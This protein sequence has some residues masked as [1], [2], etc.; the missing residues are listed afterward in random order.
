[1]KYKLFWAIVLI[2]SVVGCRQTEKKT[3]H[4]HEAHK[5]QYTAYSSAHELFAEADP[6]IAGES[7]NVLSHF[8][9]LPD[10]KALEEGKITLTLTAG[11]STVQQTLGKPDRKGIYSFDLKPV[12]AGKGSLKYE[13]TNA[14]GEFTIEVPDVTV[15]ASDEEADAAAEANEQS[16]TNTTTFTKEQSWKID[17]NTGYPVMEPFGQVIKTT[18][19]VDAAIGSESVVVAKTA[20]VVIINEEL[21]AGKMVSKGEKLFTISGTGMAENNFSTKYSEAK[22]NFE[23]AKADLQRATELAKERIV[24]ER[25]LA[26]YKNIFDNA[27]TVFDNLNSNFSASGQTVTSPVSGYIR[28]LYVTNGSFVE[29][30]QRVLTVSQ[31]KSLTLHAEIP[32][33]YAPLLTSVATA[34]IKDMSGRVFTLEQLNGKILSYG[35]AA[36]EDNYLLPVTLKIDN[37][38][39]FIPGGFVDLYLKALT[40]ESS[41]VVPST[42]IIEEQGNYFVWVQVNPELFEKR[43]VKTGRTDGLNTEIINGIS[44]A[45]RIITRGAMLVKLAQSTGTLDAHS[46]HVH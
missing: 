31:N 3:E 15:F 36:G 20:G 37:N 38:G 5:F 9:S 2:F 30:G 6:F 41:L 14:K 13:L 42:A 43:E 1:M 24:S 27:K 39:E 22:S 10:F 45:E 33:K 40:L 18:A 25:E 34:H 28:Q 7:S 35:K 11:G 8:S 21:P 4:E 23:K 19:Q 44:K 32:L 46:G 12:K 16:K 26:S 29:A 17:F